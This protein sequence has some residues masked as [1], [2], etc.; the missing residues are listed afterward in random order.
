MIPPPGAYV[1]AWKISAHGNEHT[2]T[3]FDGWAH[4]I[5]RLDETG[6]DSP[7]GRKI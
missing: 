1:G 4:K 2:K 7:L 3:F 5:I 6:E